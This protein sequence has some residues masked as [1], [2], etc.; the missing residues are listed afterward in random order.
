MKIKAIHTHGLVQSHVCSHATSPLLE[1]NSIIKNI[2]INLIHV[3]DILN[4]N[5]AHA[6][7]HAHT[8][9]YIHKTDHIL[10]YEFTNKIS[11]M[12]AEMIC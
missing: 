10:A 11:C 8:S 2:G 5:G 6:H 1:K 4:L 7:A 9:V 12:T 3:F